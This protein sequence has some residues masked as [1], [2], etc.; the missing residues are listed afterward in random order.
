MGNILERH[1]I[2]V[3]IEEE[4]ETWISKTAGN[5]PRRMSDWLTRSMYVLSAYCCV[6]TS[7]KYLVEKFM[8]VESVKNIVGVKKVKILAT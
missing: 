6:T 5:K 1:T 2:C 7:R 3:A 4:S 8:R